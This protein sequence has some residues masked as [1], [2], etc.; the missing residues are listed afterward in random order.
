MTEQGG[1]GIELWTMTEDI[2]F[3]NLYIGNSVEDAQKLAEETWKVKKQ[4]A[5]EAK[6]AA[7]AAAAEGRTADEF[8]CMRL[9]EATGICVVPG[10]GFGQKDG[11][12]HFR[13]TFLAPGTEWVGSSSLRSLLRIDTNDFCA[14]GY[15]KWMLLSHTLLVCGDVPEIRRCETSVG[16]LD[17]CEHTAP[18]ELLHAILRHFLA[19]IFSFTRF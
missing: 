14:P 10:S 3:D 15:L 9:L 8:Y 13:T 12:L 1:V 17:T 7:E 11:T 6:K 16:F 18:S 4:V 19:P 5:D 2:L